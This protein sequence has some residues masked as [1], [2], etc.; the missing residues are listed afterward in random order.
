M[1][2]KEVIIQMNDH[3]EADDEFEVS[4]LR[5]DQPP[6]V[7][8]FPA[9]AAVLAA[10][11]RQI[12]SRRRR[13]LAGIALAVAVV[14]TLALRQ[15]GG[16]LLPRPAAPAALRPS[17]AAT[18]YFE[19]GV[20]WGTLRVNGRI[21]TT[22][23][24][25][26]YLSARLILAPGA[27]QLDY[28]AAPYPPLR[29]VISDPP[30]PYDTCP[31]ITANTAQDPIHS[32]SGGRIVDLRANIAYLSTTSFSALEQATESALATL[33]ATNAQGASYSATELAPGDHYLNA[34]GRTLIATQTLDATLQYTLNRTSSVRA[35][36]GNRWPCRVFCPITASPDLMTPITP[37]WLY[38][39]VGSRASATTGLYLAPDAAKNLGVG[40]LFLEIAY[41]WDE[42]WRVSITS[43]SV[44]S[45]G[46]AIC[47]DGALILDSELSSVNFSDVQTL[48]VG[49]AQG[50][51]YSV[52]APGTPA[53]LF[54]FRCG[55]ILAANLAAQRSA[56]KLTVAAPDE[57]QVA[58]T[59][60]V[61]AQSLGV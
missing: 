31:L 9:F 7:T 36:P 40:E 22:G 52:Q 43:Y 25:P 14:A 35:T 12:S 58:Q 17:A 26:G 13:A 27:S 24:T 5:A 29:C 18:L 38:S 21:V 51:A 33:R 34:Q 2:L 15:Y 46:Q 23:M 19:D 32:P 30:A 45:T 37:S 41:T 11:A 48:G 49:D 61:L 54:L 53:A 44:L 16:A 1:Y 3:P 28:S 6:G 56:P 50:C 39:P 8:R 20:S 47:N 4:D 42:R 10:L 55:V 57:A 60:A 59:V